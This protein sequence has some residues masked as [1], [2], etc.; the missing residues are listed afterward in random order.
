[1]AVVDR[2]DSMAVDRTAAEMVVVVAIEA[3]TRYLHLQPGPVGENAAL[4]GDAAAAAV[5]GGPSSSGV[6]RCWSA[7]GLARGADGSSRGGDR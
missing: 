1:M 5:L 4:F 7:C 2:A 6:G 3:H